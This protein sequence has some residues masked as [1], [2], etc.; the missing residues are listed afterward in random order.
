MICVNFVYFGVPPWIPWCL[1]LLA[2]E[3]TEGWNAEL[4]SV[5]W[6]GPASSLRM[7]VIVP[8]SR[9]FQTLE[10]TESRPSPRELLQVDLVFQLSRIQTRRHWRTSVMPRELTFTILRRPP[11]Q[12]VERSHVVL[13][14]QA[15]RWEQW[16]NTLAASEQWELL[17]RQRARVDAYRRLARRTAPMEIGRAHV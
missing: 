9:F 17:L 3:M 6:S 12:D 7:R 4:A 11:P 5:A 1:L 16:E 15:H 14:H 2:P 8:T 13:E 10:P